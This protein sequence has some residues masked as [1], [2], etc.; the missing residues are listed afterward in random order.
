[1]SK[2]L[3]EAIAWWRHH[4]VDAVKDW[5]GVTPDDWQ[6]DVL[7]DLFASEGMARVAAKSCHGAGKTTAE[8]WAHWIFMKTRSHGRV[9]A[10]APTQSQL[11]DVLWPEIAKWHSKM[12]TDLAGMWDISET[13]VRHKKF[14]KT[15]F[16]VARTSNKQENLQGF[17][18][19]NICVLVDEASGVRADVFEV[20]EGILSEA[21]QIGK[22]AKIFMVGNPTQLS[23]EF[24][25]AF[26]KNAD[27]YK[28]YTI[29]GDN[30][31]PTDRYGGR[32]FLSNRVTEAYRQNIARKYGR[33]GP[34]YDVRVRG[35][36]PTE[37]DDSIIPLSW[38][39]NAQ[40]VQP[41]VFDRIAH[42]YRLVMDVA[43]MGTD[44]TVLGVFRGN[45]CLSLQRWPKTTTGQCVDILKEARDSIVQQGFIVSRIIVDEP[46]IGGGVIDSGRRAGLM[47]TPYHG[48]ASPSVNSNDPE[49]DVRMF[50][51]RRARDF[52]HLRRMLEMN[53]ISIP[54]DEALVNQ[55]ASVKY[56]YQESTDKI[57]VES[58]GEM[59]DR[60]GEDGS[61][62][63][64]DCLVM[65]FAPEYSF[66][67]AMPG[68]ILALNADLD[69]GGLRNTSV[70]DFREFV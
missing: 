35:L 37:A 39:E 40:Y 28:L 57:K 1:M 36:F 65:G 51:N 38:A 42:P 34:V 5:F 29:C 9:V 46:G 52:W 70:H 17:H 60:L 63:E 3:V 50:L 18:G 4:P 19:T 53:Q 69:F 20:L 14:P 58:K 48:G 30:K 6:G 26:H 21:G 8:S 22:E 56:K 59:K 45:A 49:E 43:R 33:N 11:R 41:P 68:E 24:Y 7:N 31:M 61:P 12:H 64:T 54:E 32:I 44:K 2:R 13:H 15:W 67:K 23:G 47:I 25:N 62:D 66:I 27:L 16:S 55:M 10:T